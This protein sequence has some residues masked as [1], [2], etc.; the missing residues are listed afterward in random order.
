MQLKNLDSPLPHHLAEVVVLV[1]CLMDP[2][3]IIE[4]QR[5]AI[6]RRES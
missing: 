1:F 3:H 6:L 5:A 4:E 2:Q